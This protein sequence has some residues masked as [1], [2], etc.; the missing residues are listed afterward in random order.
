MEVTE[1]KTLY[2][3]AWFGLI[4]AIMLTN[5]TGMINTFAAVVFGLIAIW[6]VLIMYYWGDHFEDEEQRIG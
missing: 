6:L 3:L 5:L 4:M 1:M 2:I